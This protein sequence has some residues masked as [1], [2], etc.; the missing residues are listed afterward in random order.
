MKIIKILFLPFKIRKIF[1]LFLAI[2][3]FR[4]YQKLMIENHPFKNF[5]KKIWCNSVE[6]PFEFF[7]YYD[8]FSYWIIKKINE[9]G[10]N[11]KILDVGGKKITNAILS[12]NNDVIAVVLKDCKDK[13]SKVRYVIHDVSYPLP[14]EDNT[15]DV[16]T[17][18]ATLHLIGL[19]RYGDK[20]DPNALI[21]FVKE[22]DRVMKKKSD[23]FLC[24]PLGKNQLIFNLHY[25]FDFDTLKDILE[26]GK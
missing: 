9:L 12:I 10:N 4:K 3:N 14:F 8:V 21:N 23:L 16:F 7:N 17:S 15:F 19:G 13:I 20:L 11:K 18:P 2:K 6:D 22:L 26:I 1:G 5:K 24:M 25:I